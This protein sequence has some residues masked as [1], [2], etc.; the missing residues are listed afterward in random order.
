MAEN[1]PALLVRLS[2]EPLTGLHFICA[3][4]RGRAVPSLVALRASLRDRTR[5]AKDMALDAEYTSEALRTSLPQALEALK[6]ATEAVH[7]TRQV[8][9]LKQQQDVPVV[10]SR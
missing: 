5:T 8:I 6:K 10:S 4:A 3:H 9:S 1:V 7:R 2:A